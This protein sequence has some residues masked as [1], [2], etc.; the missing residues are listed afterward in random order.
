VDLIIDG[1][2][3]S[4]YPFSGGS[5]GVQR[6]FAVVVHPLQSLSAG[7]S[8]YVRYNFNYYGCLGGSASDPNPDCGASTEPIVVN[9]EWSFIAGELKAAS[10]EVPRSIDLRVTGEYTACSVFD[11]V[12]LTDCELQCRQRAVVVHRIQVQISDYKPIE[13]VRVL[14]LSACRNPATNE[15]G[16]HKKTA[17]FIPQQPGNTEQYWLTFSVP[18]ELE[19]SSD[20]SLPVSAEIAVP[21]DDLPVITK[22]AFLP[23]NSVAFVPD[24]PCWDV[25][26]YPKLGVGDGPP[27]VMPMNWPPCSSQIH[28]NEALSS[29]ETGSDIGPEPVTTHDVGGGCTTAFNVNEGIVGYYWLVLLAVMVLLLVAYKAQ[30]P[31]NPASKGE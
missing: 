10:P 25:D 22:N 18:N 5:A 30:C 29:D 17:L 4:D 9:R 19:A 24:Q 13:D 3:V 23:V 14:I 2:P 7:V 8:Y 12:M 27:S 11:C 16:C 15:T 1:S 21:E 6:Y 28:G 26:F 31:K 20:C